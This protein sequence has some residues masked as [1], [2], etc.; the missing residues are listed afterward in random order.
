MPF[1][2]ASGVDTAGKEPSGISDRVGPAGQ[3]RAAAV[4]ERR[5]AAP[6]ARYSTCSSAVPL[7][8]RVGEAF[9]DQ[10]KLQLCNHNDAVFDHNKA[11]SNQANSLFGD[12]RH[13]A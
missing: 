12:A 8:C 5:R 1:I 13:F 7:M 2:V 11:T 4:P 6:R 10:R 3:L 9:R